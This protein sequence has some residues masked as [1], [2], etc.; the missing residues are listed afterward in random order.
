MPARRIVASRRFVALVREHLLASDGADV[1]DLIVADA[2]L[3]RAVEDGMDVQ[4]RALRLA[5]DLAE[6]VDQFFLQFIRQVV[7]QHAMST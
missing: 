4:R 7:L 2:K 5:A 3:R 1:T 6:S